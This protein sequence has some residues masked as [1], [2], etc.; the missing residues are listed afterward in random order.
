VDRGNII[1]HKNI[2]LNYNNN[3]DNDILAE[4]N[5]LNGPK[6]NYSQKAEYS[7]L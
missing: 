6:V 7:S 3:K 2:G 4:S 1:E 5:K